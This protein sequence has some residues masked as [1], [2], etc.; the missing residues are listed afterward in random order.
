MFQHSHPVFERAAHDDYDDLD[1]IFPVS[2]ARRLCGDEIAAALIRDFGG[3]RLYF[4]KVVGDDHPLAKSLGRE[5]AQKIAEECWGVSG[6]YIPLGF[7]ERDNRRALVAVLL[8]DGKTV[9][10]I[11]RRAK[12]SERTIRL[13]IAALRKAGLVIDPKRHT[14]SKREKR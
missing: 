4:P 3:Q 2:I 6:L 1:G 7:G 11:A 14:K 8:A 12:R 9:P 10:E 5:N 13:D